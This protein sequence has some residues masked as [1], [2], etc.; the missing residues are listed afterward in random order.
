MLAATVLVLLRAALVSHSTLE[1]GLR[2]AA[3][4]G[5]FAALLPLTLFDCPLQV[6]ATAQ[7]AFLAAGVLA[8]GLVGRRLSLSHPRF[9]GAMMAAFGLALGAYLGTQALAGVLADG[10][11]IEARELGA[12]LSPGNPRLQLMVATDWLARGRLD[13]CAMRAERALATA[14][15]FQ[16]AGFILEKCAKGARR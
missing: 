12:Q 7:L 9:T 15:T 8:P 4:L 14:P 13:R 6:A 1:E 3:L 5:L 16:L 2:A 11:T 10:T